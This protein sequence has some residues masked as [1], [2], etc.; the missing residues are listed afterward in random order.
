MRPI[1]QHIPARPGT[2]RPSR[3]AGFRTAASI[4]LAACLALGATATTTA[5]TAAVAPATQPVSATATVTTGVPAPTAASAP[6]AALAGG[7]QGTKPQAA[8]AAA[9]IAEQMAALPV[10]GDTTP[11]HDPALIVARDGTWWVYGTGRVKRENGGTIQMWS[12]SDGGTTWRYRGTVWNKIPTW[13]DQHFAGGELPE[14]LW[15]PEVYEHGGTYYLYYSASRFGTNT[16]VTALATNTTLDPNDPAYRWVDQGLVV[17]SPATGLPGG[18]NFNAIDAGIVESGGKP[19]MSI[20]SFFDG[21]FLV[22]LQWPS[23]KVAVADWAPQTVQ[24]AHRRV[25]GNPIEAPYIKE[26]GGYFYLFTSFDS[27]CKGTSSTYKIAVGRSRSVTGPYLD[28]SGKSMLNGGGTILLQ[29]SGTRIGPGGQSVFGDDLAYHYYDSTKNG[30][31]TLAIDRMTWTNGWPTIGAQTSGTS[32]LR[33]VHTGTCLDVAAATAG[34]PATAWSCNGLANQR[35]TATASDELRVFGSLCLDAKDR[36]T[37]PGTA[38]IVWSCTGGTN[39]KW[40]AQPDGTIRGTQSGLC[41]DVSGWGTTNGTPMQLW[42]CT[43]AANQR[44]TRS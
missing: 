37:T 43:G 29:S 40:V 31:P 20:G 1:R 16:S 4:A 24:L 18:A 12:S 36:R 39:Q 14:N 2:A 25:S 6:D 10:T 13:I 28:R 32:T 33:N 15:A 44:F 21:I 17:A 30:T 7:T 27:C 35:W 42:T 11:I 22:P 5:A 38:V 26:R 9:R 3:R 23:G 41:L 19:Y 8:A 34:T